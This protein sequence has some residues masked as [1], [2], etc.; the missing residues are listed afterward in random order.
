MLPSPQWQDRDGNEV[1]K[2]DPTQFGCLVKHRLLHPECIVAFDE[3]GDNTNLLDTKVNHHNKLLVERNSRKPLESASTNDIH[4]TSVGAV[5]LTGDAVAG[6]LNIKKGRS[7]K[8]KEGIEIPLSYNEL[9][10]ADFEAPFIGPLPVRIDDV[11]TEEQITLNTGPGKRWPGVIDTV[12]REKTIP[13]YLKG[14]TGGGVTPKLLVGFLKHIDERNVYNR[15]KHNMNPTL[16]LDGHDSRMS[17]PFLIYINNLKE[18][19]SLDP[20][21]DHYWNVTLGVPYA[22]GYWQIGD[23]P[24]HNTAYKF[25]SSAYKRQLCKRTKKNINTYKITLI[26]N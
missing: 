4:Y 24:Q 11:L 12:F 25:H 17:A 20:D 13:C 8:G 15:K 14:S 18:D 6:S 21:A 16:L 23:A 1:D 26:Y 22:T 2:E 10:G 19:G 9:M 5:C 7:T 3:T